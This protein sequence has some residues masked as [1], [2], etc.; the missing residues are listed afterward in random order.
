MIHS[1]SAT[2]SS[3][4]GSWWIHGEN[5]PWMGCQFITG[6]HTD[7]NT[8]GQFSGTK[9]PERFSGGSRDPENMGEHAQKLHPDCNLS[10]GSN[11]GPWSCKDTMLPAAPN[12]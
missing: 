8:Q 10:A 9:P 2:A 3:L 11:R 1:P 5:S 4:S 7:I 6:N 12:F